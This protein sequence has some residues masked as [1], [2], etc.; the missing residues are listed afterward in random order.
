MRAMILSLARFQ[1][2]PFATWDHHLNYSSGDSPASRH[3]FELA[4]LFNFNP[5]FL[6]QHF[7]AMQQHP[8]LRQTGLEVLARDSSR[9]GVQ[10]DEVEV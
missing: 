10:Y 7:S 9:D 6:I 2:A 4:S 8:R 5:L 1:V 3:I